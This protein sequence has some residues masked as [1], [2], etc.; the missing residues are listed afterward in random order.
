MM[1]KF[2]LLGKGGASLF[3]LLCLFFPLLANNQYQ[4]ALMTNIFILALATLG[5]N[6]ITG[7]TGQLNLAHGSFMAIGAYTVAL[8]MVKG[9]WPFWPALLVAVLF[10]GMLGALLGTVALR[11]KDHYFAI[12]TMSLGVIILLILE[13]WDSLTEGH[14]GIF[15]IEPPEGFG[16]IDF[17]QIL[18]QYYLALVMLL[19]GLLVMWRITLSLLGRTFIAIRNSEPLAQA[20]GINTM[21]AKLLSF[22]LSTCYGGLAGGLYS[23]IVRFVDPS[24]ANIAFT[25][26]MI[27]FMLVGGIGLLFG[28]IVGCVLLM[29]L[30]QSLQFL[31]EY[32][33]L[34]FGPI[35]IILVIYF[36]HGLMGYLHLRRMRRL[37]RQPSSNATATTK[38]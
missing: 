20:I 29:W 15:G 1:N 11:L 4:V 37:T 16:L 28:P 12:F 13:K 17:H 36:P 26:D 23:G 21:R 32:R 7:Y 5:L 25:F 31:Q 33:M 18:P 3:F 14:N 19:I 35:L 38:V 6:L 10:T 34:I 9:G 30:V 2:S 8:L 24:L 22:T 27:T